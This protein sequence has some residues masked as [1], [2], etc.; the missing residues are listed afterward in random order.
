MSI[1]KVKDDLTQK[2]ELIKYD[3][4]NQNSVNSRKK[5]SQFFTP[6]NIATFMSSLIEIKNK[7]E[8]TILD[9]GA[10]TGI[11]SVSIVEHLINL[12]QKPEKLE[13][14]AIEIDPSLI[15]HLK[16]SYEI[17]YERC[18][19]VNINFTCKIIN[20]DFIKYGCEE[21][22]KSDETS[23]F[24]S[25]EGNNKFD[26]IILNPPY[27]KIDSSSETSKLLNS[28]G[29]ESTNLYSSFLELSSH[30]IKEDGQI[31][32]ITPRSFCNGTYFRKFRQK[33]FNKLFLHKIH[34]YEHRNKAFSEDDVLQE[35]LIF[36]TSPQTPPDGKVIIT[37]SES[38]NDGLL[39][40][41][42]IDHNFIILPEDRSKIIHIISDEFSLKIIDRI[43]SLKN[44]LKDIKLNVSTGKVI[45]FRVAEYLKN[46]YELNTTALFYP[47]HFKNGTI[48]W[49]QNPK[50]K[51]E[52]IALNS[53]IINSMVKSGYYVFC[54]RFSSKEEKK[55]VDAA[56]YDFKNFDFELIGIENHLNYFHRNNEPLTK[57]I[58]QGLTL[59]LNSTIVDQ[60]F[61]LFNG[62]T[63]VNADDLRF[64]FYPSIEQ[65]IKLS[66]YFDNG[67]PPQEKIDEIIEKELF[68]MKKGQNPTLITSKIDEAINILKQIGIP[69][70]QQN[71]RSALTL[72]ALLNLKPSQKWS[73]VKSPMLGITMIMDFIKENYGKTYAPNT[74]E[75]I[76]RQTVHQFVQAGIVLPNPDKPRPINSP[77]FIYQIE[78]SALNLLKKIKS[79][80]WNNLLKKYLSSIKTLTEIYAQERD[81]QKIPLNIT[82]KIK[83]TLSEGGQN[84]LIEK[85]INEFCPIF[86]PKGKLL[87][88]GDAKS[89]WL[90]F[91]EK[92]F[93]KLGI[94]IENT[95]G[96]M[97]D[98]IIHYTKENW[99]ILI[100]A[101]TSHGPID[102]KRK[103]ELEKLFS[104][105]NIGLV[106]ITT[107][108]DKNTMT[109]HLNKI[110][111]ETDIW[112]A[113]SPTH[114]IHLNG[115]RF[116]GPYIKR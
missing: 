45:D 105:Y 108:L 17:C 68:S 53:E 74:R 22:I 23:L 6:S 104:N 86:T 97:P 72:L 26:L 64:I 29:I 87:Y 39:K 9:P 8:I 101:V 99:L 33:I 98:V 107:F 50:K 77:H 51:K 55:R 20:K 12:E 100:E 14:I 47:F 65:L 61:R 32:A 57:E 52:L 21:I 54:K 109:K 70:D 13:I 19:E 24:V 58:A 114:L 5:Y 89:K 111:W 27:K 1:F 56:F 11:L 59:Y 7:K 95:H 49:P 34:L 63:Q 18:K 36:L 15:D 85:V 60:Y 16:R 25:N 88:I 84:E 46:K 115:K 30:L 28:A 102:P 116:L 80:N 69:K 96:K 42:S 75:T 4:L 31:I 37:T 110:A 79:K 90:H 67:L 106:F 82:K 92:G 3:Y 73:E 66:Y 93:K 91:D 43:S 71:E 2:A 81:L 41:I 83:I 40:T 48:V 62:H 112:V 76:R 35:N 103:I 44:K 38:P 10:G 113:S 94:E 78:P